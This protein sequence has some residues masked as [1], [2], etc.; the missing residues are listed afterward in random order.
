MQSSNDYTTK[1]ERV[2]V[3]G[4]R[5]AERVRQRF[6]GKVTVNWVDGLP[7]SEEVFIRQDFSQSCS[8]PTNS[9]QP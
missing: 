8:S 5:N 2:T 9:K 1:L 4:A 7:S 6:T 3:L